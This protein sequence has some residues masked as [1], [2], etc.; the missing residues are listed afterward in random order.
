MTGILTPRL[1]L[2][3]ADPDDYANVD[4]DINDN[5]DILDSAMPPTVCTSGSRP[6]TPYQG[7]LIYES[8][9]NRLLIR[10]ATNK[11][12]TITARE[13]ATTQKATADVAVTNTSGV[14]DRTVGKILSHL[15]LV[16]DGIATYRFRA[17][18]GGFHAS[19]DPGSTHAMLIAMERYTA[20]V[21]AG[22]LNTMAQMWRGADV[23]P[24]TIP[25]AGGSFE[26]DYK[27][28][29][30]TWDFH[31]RAWR[32]NGNTY[33]FTIDAGSAYPIQFSVTE[34]PGAEY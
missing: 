18:F 20:G 10:T 1:G 11:W 12:R 7:Q 14:T 17:T 26:V 15:A 13:V 3:K 8:D 9:T 6:S 28:P 24:S 32:N 25:S 2:Y 5:Y 30:G 21:A 16:C 34:L 31:L 23:S 27:P 4:T 22:Y 29:A 33:S 19:G